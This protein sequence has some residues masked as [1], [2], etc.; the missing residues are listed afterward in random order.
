MSEIPCLPE[1]A[2]RITDFMTDCGGISKA[3]A[4]A[5]AAAEAKAKAEAE[6]KAATQKAA[7]EKEA[8]EA[9]V[10]ILANIRQCLCVC[11]CSKNAV[12]FR[13]MDFARAGSSSSIKGS[14]Y[15]ECQTLSVRVQ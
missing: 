2:C 9:K 4:K 11:I 1:N 5:K 8:A 12:C 10:V 13:E 14:S 6:A 15:R 3:A 7:A